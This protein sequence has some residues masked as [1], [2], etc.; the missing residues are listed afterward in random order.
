MTNRLFRR[1]IVGATGIVVGWALCAGPGNAAATAPPDSTP[2]TSVPA[3]EGAQGTVIGGDAVEQ[4]ADAVPQTLPLIPARAGCTPPPLP[5]VVFIGTVTDQDY[6]S[7]QFQ[8]ESIRDGSPAP[9]ETDGRISVRFGHEAQYLKLG[10]QYLVSAMRDPDLGILVSRLTDPVENFGGDEV[11][12]V[13]E[14]DV[15]CPDYEDPERTLHPDGTAVEVNI[16]EPLGDAGGQLLAAILLPL[17]VVFGAIFALSLVRI[18]FD[19][20]ARFLIRDSRR[21]P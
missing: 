9:Y 7:V 8:I 16:L 2:P 14:S 5:Q 21:Y 20:I 3:E 4:P 17:G 19:G 15:R 12:G 1:V 10:D 13:N 11:I 18:S 6:R